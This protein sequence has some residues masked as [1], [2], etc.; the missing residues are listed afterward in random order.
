M[1]VGRG[2]RRGVS[3]PQGLAPA[4]P[5]PPEAFS[6]APTRRSLMDAPVRSAPPWSSVVTR[7]QR[8]ESVQAA[9]A[10]TQ[11]Q[12]APRYQRHLPERTLLYQVIERHY[13][14]F[15]SY[16][17]DQGKTLPRHVQR[18]FEDYLQCGRLEHGFLRLRCERCHAEH[19][20]AFSCKR[21]G[22]CPS[23]G[24]RRMAE[25]AA[26]L[27]DAVLPHRPIRQWVL[28][29]LYPLRFLFA[30]R[31]AILGQVLGIVYRVI[32]AHLIRQAGQTHRTARTGAITQ[33]QHFGLLRL[34]GR[35]KTSLFCVV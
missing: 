20:L 33:I 16:L 22:I 8:M 25:N 35:S 24:A 3:P 5:S 29:F 15:V 32:A 18:T 17:A 2:Q 14:A 28:S 12:G 31:P 7:V 10:R 26:W 34:C 1:R 21:R 4:T 30:T 13:P 19:L 9:A 23:C 11:G 27:V 6:Y